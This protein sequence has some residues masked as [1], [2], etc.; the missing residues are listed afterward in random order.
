M[1]FGGPVL[2]ALVALGAVLFVAVVALVVRVWP[3]APVV[4]KRVVV[5]TKEDRTIEGVL[6]ARRGPLLVLRD[7]AVHHQGQRVPADGEV[8]VERSTVAWVQVLP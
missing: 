6:F 1:T 5:V 4:R 7:A 8:I 2:I 3:W